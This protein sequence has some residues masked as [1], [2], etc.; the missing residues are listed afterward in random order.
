VIWKQ[1]TTNELRK[2]LDVRCWMFNT[3]P[4][5]AFI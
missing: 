1:R 3:F 2:P 4:P 5:C